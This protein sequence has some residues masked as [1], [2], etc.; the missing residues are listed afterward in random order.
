VPDAVTGL[1]R[2]KTGY[3]VDNFSN[4]FTVCDFYNPL[5]GTRFR[6]LELTPSMEIHDSALIVDATS[7]TNY[8]VTGG[9]ITMPYTEVP[10]INQNVS[11]RVTNINHFL[12]INWEGHMTIVPPIDNWIDTEFLPEIFNVVNNTVVVTRENHIAIFDPAPA[13]PVQTPIPAAP[14]TINIG[15]PNS[16]SIANATGQTVVPF[17]ANA[18]TMTAAGVYTLNPWVTGQIARDWVVSQINS[19][20]THP[21][22]AGE[23][24]G[25]ILLDN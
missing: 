12:L 13:E 20:Q 1:N 9:Q 24:V 10:F 19:G 16:L 18:V 22:T 4:P 8:Q 15:I 21:R 11:T 23:N 7:S 25:H 6:S 5:S 2:F 17:P 14:P 3:L